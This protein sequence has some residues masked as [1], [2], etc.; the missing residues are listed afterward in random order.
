MRPA[1]RDLFHSEGPYLRFVLHWHLFPRPHYDLRLE[2]GGKLWSWAVPK[3]PSLEPGIR[4]LAL[5]QKEHALSCLNVEMAGQIMVWDHGVYEPQGGEAFVHEMILRDA[6]QRGLIRF[7]LYGD[8]LRGG[9]ELRRMADGGWLLNKLDDEFASSRDV[10]QLGGPPLEDRPLNRNLPPPPPKRHIFRIEV[11]RFYALP[12]GEDTPL[13]VVRDGRVID[14]NENARAYGVKPGDALRDA[15]NLIPHV[16]VHHWQA[17]DYRERQAAWLDACTEFSDTIE[18]DDQHAAYLDLTNH[19]APLDIADRAVAALQ[20]TTGLPIRFGA[21]PSKWIAALATGRGIWGEAVKDPG[22]FLAPLPVAALQA[23]PPNVRERLHFL[24]YRSIGE[25]A[26]L[27]LGH[28]QNQFGGETGLLI[29]QAATGVLTESV[30]ATYPPNSVADRILF[31]DPVDSLETLAF[32]YGRLADR[33]GSH[34]S[35]KGLEGS[36]LEFGRETEDAGWTTHAR[37]FARP[38]RCERTVLTGIKAVA[39]ACPPVDTVSGVRVRMKNLKRV[40]SYQPAFVGRAMADDR[41]VQLGRALTQLQTTFGETSVRRA[42]EVP[43]ERRVRVLK[44][45]QRALG[46]R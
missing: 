6:L 35:Q 2:V 36:H 28:L 23:L 21:G 38:L 43:I 17:D 46:W 32:N 24:G 45:W 22:R 3:G 33:L 16:K 34:L 25:V 7:N 20:K 14:A 44:E 9:W 1:Q 5:L 10:R 27:G 13:V 30:R 19:P 31:P 12:L 8:R 42:S 29:H 37:E 15:S 11:D 41:A 40:Q 18:P 4:R 26:E 39:G